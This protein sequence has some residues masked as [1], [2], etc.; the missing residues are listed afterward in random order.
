MLVG[1]F[2]FKIDL[3]WV[4]AGHRLLQLHLVGMAVFVH[5]GLPARPSGFH[6]RFKKT[7]SDSAV[8]RCRHDSATVWKHQIKLSQVCKKSLS[9]NILSL[10]DGSNSA[11]GDFIRSKPVTLF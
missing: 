2:C 10:H 9:T 3:L 5:S 6:V 1:A 8:E 11:A 7:T 4:Q